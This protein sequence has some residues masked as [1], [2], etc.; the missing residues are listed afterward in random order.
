MDKINLYNF[1]SLL[2]L[3]DFGVSKLLSET[4]QMDTL[5][6]TP[7]YIAPEVVRA[8]QRPFERYTSKADCWSLGVLLYQLLTGERPF[9]SRPD[10]YLARSICTTSVTPCDCQGP[11]DGPDPDRVVR[12]PGGEGQWGGQP[13][14]HGPP[15]GPGRSHGY[16]YYGLTFIIAP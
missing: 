1:R 8:A 7:Y 15:P 6:G 13:F 9:Q 4:G 2:K 5:V 11:C 3:A 10:R 14:G 12:Q 16:G